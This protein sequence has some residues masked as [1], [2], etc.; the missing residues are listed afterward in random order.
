MVKKNF[1]MVGLSES[2]FKKKRKINLIKNSKKIKILVA[3]QC[4]IDSPHA[5]GNWFF[6]DFVDW[7]EYLGRI[8]EKTNYEWYI[9]P[10]PNNL[11]RNKEFIDYYLKKYPKF[12]L[13]PPNTSHYSLK[14]KIDFVFTNWGNIAMDLALL[15]IKVLNT[16]QNGRFSS[17]NFNI[18]SNTFKEYNSKILN[19]KKN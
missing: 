3:T 2:P 4:L 12:K 16:H 5:F 7:L 18:N 6:S 15:D 8:S 10:H 1:N 17:F 19:L 13:V 9:K 14:N 11:R